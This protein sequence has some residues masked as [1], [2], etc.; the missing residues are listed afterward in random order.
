[1]FAL[2]IFAIAGAFAIL[3]LFSLHV[4]SQSDEPGYRA[5]VAAKIATFRL[6]TGY[7]YRTAMDA[8]ASQLVVVAAGGRR[9]SFVIELEGIPFPVT[10]DD[11]QLIGAAKVGMVVGTLRC[12]KPVEDGIDRIRSSLR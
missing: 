7:G 12:K 10:V 9:R 4:A 5:R 2:A 8:F 3:T 6:P 1:M 11:A